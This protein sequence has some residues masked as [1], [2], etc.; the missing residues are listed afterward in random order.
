[1]ENRTPPEG[2]TFRLSEIV[3]LFEIKRHFVIHLVDSG[4]IK[5]FSDAKGRGKARA[6]SYL[7]LIEIAVCLQLSKLEVSY[8]TIKQLLEVIEE[9]W[10]KYHHL[11]FGYILVIGYVDG[12]QKVIPKLEPLGSHEYI[13]DVLEKTLNDLRAEEPLR[14]MAFSYYFGV[15][16]FNLHAFIDERI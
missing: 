13:E 16:I 15:D 12:R 5:P 3:R 11:G 7:N 14:S 4:L 8:S 2:R 10:S 9:Q 1:V 6:Y